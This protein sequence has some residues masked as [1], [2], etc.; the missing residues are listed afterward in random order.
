MILSVPRDEDV[1]E[2]LHPMTEPP[3][4][5]CVEVEDIWFSYDRRSDVLRGVSLGIEQGAVTAVLGR[6]GS[7]KTSL[8]RIIKG[9]LH[10][11]RGTVRMPLL[12]G[13]RDISYI[14]QTLGLVRTLSALE[15]T[16]V[17]ASIRIN[18]TRSLLR[19]FP[20]DVRDEAYETLRKLG[21]G[22]KA[23]EPVHRLSGGERQR[24][25][26]AR[27]LMQNPALILADEFVSQ[28]DPITAEEVLEQM[29]EIASEGVALLIT[30]HQTDV[31]ADYADRIVVMSDGAVVHDTP[32]GDI[33]IA[34]VREMMR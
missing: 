34:D 26:I 31:A 12:N 29:R 5:V 32:A 19:V 24:V 17:G 27:S 33:P 15:N 13:P 7:G 16:A 6:S 10:P 28:L 25:A 14:P 30:T 21:L 23:N 4:S 2:A 18:F 22:H 1:A 20:S 11:S 3:R 9:I 8:L